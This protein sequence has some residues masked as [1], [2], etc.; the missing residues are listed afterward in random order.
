[1]ADYLHT[2]LFGIYP[3]L[4]LSVFLLGSL[5]RFDREQ[6]TWRSGSSQLLRARQLR[7]GSNLF[8]I[9]IL[10]LFAGHLVGL[11]T[12]HAVYELAIGAGTKQMLAIVSGG[13]AG[14]I[15][16]V[17]LSLLLHRRLSD[18]RIRRTS[19]PM[20]IAILWLLWVQLV[21]GMI[22]LPY[23]LAHRDGSVMV[24][25]SEWAQHI[26]T[27]R[28]GAADFVAGVAWPYQL[29]V[30]LGLTIFLVFPFSRLVHVW[31]APIW[32]VFR[33]PQIVRR[34]GPGMPAR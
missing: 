12:P 22:T 9:G 18:P 3:Y 11:L 16:F 5:I 15:C 14:A 23:S 20:D 30:V 32:Y 8:H 21:L 4:C 27:F 26:V 28:G 24:Q 7:W 6:Y 31:S 13:I 19:N 25:L 2:F 34:R 17:G 1:M 10:F 33:R 29:H